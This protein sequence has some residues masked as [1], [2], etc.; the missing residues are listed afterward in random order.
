[1]G[2]SSN[3]SGFEAANSA[4]EVAFIVP[5]AVYDEHG[6]KLAPPADLAAWFKARTD[7]TAT[8]SPVQLGSAKGTL[9]VGTLSATAHTN[10]AGGVNVLCANGYTKCNFEEGGQ[11]GFLPGTRFE[12]LFA[13]VAG[14]QIVFEADAPP[15]DWATVGPAFDAFL[16]S[17]RFPG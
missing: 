11:I 7:L 15:A 8:S 3:S 12:F 6:Q 17:I 13:T 9:V 10:T 2:D 4:D 16:R 5:V 14:K 1:I